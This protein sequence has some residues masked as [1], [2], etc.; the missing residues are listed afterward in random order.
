MPVEEEYYINLHVR[1]KFVHDPHVRYL[2]G[3]MVKLTEDPNTI[4][5]NLQDN[6]R[7]VWNDSSIIDMINYWVKHKEIDLYVE[8]EIE[9]VVFIDVESLLAVACLQFGGNGNE[10]GEDGEVIDSKCSESEGEG[11]EVVGN[12]SGEGE[13]GGRREDGEVAGS[14]GGKG[15]EGQGIEKGGEVAKGLGRE[16]NDVT[17]S[18]GGESDGSGEEGVRDKSDS[19]SEDKNAYLMKVMYLSNGDDDGEFQEAG[20]KVKEVEGKTSGKNKETILD[21]TKSERSGEQ[22]EPKFPKEV[23]G[24][25]LNDSVEDDD[26]TDVC[27]RRSRFP[28]YNPNSA[29]RHFCIEMLFK[30]GEQFKSAIR[31]YSMCCRR[32]LKIIMNEPN[33]DNVNELRLKNLGSTIKMAVNRGTPES[34]PHFKSLFVAD[35]GMKDG[36]GYTIISDQQKGLEIAINDILPRVDHR[37]YAR[38]ILSNW[39]STKKAKTFEFAFWKVVKSTTEREWEQNKEDL[40]KLDECVANELFS[41][42]SKA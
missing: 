42:N 20:Q 39:S 33:R 1:G 31:K 17:V 32:E 13:G 15:V 36:F 19:N 25:G 14:K 28:T 41:K 5:K 11:G 6:L 10:G 22:F 40:Y 35:L 16:G 3:E 9:T 7:V 2:G 27:K 30:D 26:N 4:S 37:N 12:K 34:L 18:E 23:D 24:E 21:E 38:H 29:S 8:Y